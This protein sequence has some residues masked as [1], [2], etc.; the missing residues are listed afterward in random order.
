MRTF[1]A[2]KVLT[3]FVVLCGLALALAL[4]SLLWRVNWERANR[5]AIIVGDLDDLR[6]F[7]VREP[8]YSV[9]NLLLESGLS[10]F[11]VPEYSAQEI[12][13]GALAS[14]FCSPATSLP[15]ELRQLLS[16]PTGTVILLED[17]NQAQAQAEFLQLRFPEGEAIQ[18]GLLWLFRIPWAIQDLGDSG[19]LPDF[20]AMESLSSAGIPMIYRPAPLH[21]GRVEELLQGLEYLFNRFPSIRA[22]APSRDISA[23]FPHTTAL[24][25]LI[26]R[27]GILAVQL[28]FS[29][30]IGGAQLVW[31]S[32]PSIVS[33]HGVSEEEIITRKIGRSTMMDRLF[34]AAQE[35]SVRLLLLRTDKLRSLPQTLAEYSSD[36]A[37]LRARLDRGGIGRRWPLAAPSRSSALTAAVGL[38]LLT[39]TLAVRYVERFS[40]LRLL[41]RWRF[42]LPLLALF[43]GAL[44]WKVNLAARLGGAL[45]TGFL[46]TEAALLAL[47]RWKAPLRGLPAALAM[48][49]LGGLMVAAF[50]S[51]PAYMMRLRTFSGVKVTLLLPLLLLLLLDLQRREHPESLAQI[52]GRPP[53]WSE[54]LLGGVVLVAALILVVR[55]DNS[56]LIPGFEIQLREWLE[57]VLVARPRNK[58]LVVGYPCLV[59]W[60]YLKRSQLWG[61]YRE[62]LRLGTTLAFSS[63]V[64]S[65]CHFHTVLSLTVLRVFNGWWTGLL[66]GSVALAILASGRWCLAKVLDL[67]GEPS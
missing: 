36:V 33:F 60:Y 29:T 11:I 64:N 8:L 12:S 54:L 6:R 28:E 3:P 19:L 1:R 53:R 17:P 24:G 30:Q 21:T 32:W 18:D 66:V 7:A 58:E 13:Q 10:A 20:A 15:R 9:C 35:R 50:F 57:R 34:R 41:R 22:L 59:L 62:V 44:I 51:T 52:M 40:N 2:P 25:D 43:L 5:S 31:A 27:R 55:S 16:D 56:G 42:L 23:A 37:Q 4:P 49:L 47:E 48:V 61:R 65:F 26:K 67:T 14:A 63:A 45:A 38:A 46:A 39:L